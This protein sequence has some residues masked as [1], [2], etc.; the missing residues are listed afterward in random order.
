M[1]HEP[2]LPGGDKPFNLSAFCRDVVLSGIEAVRDD[3]SEMKERIMLARQCGILS[4]GETERM[5]AENGLK[6]A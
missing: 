5:I 6:H 4:D 2:M 1:R 3:P